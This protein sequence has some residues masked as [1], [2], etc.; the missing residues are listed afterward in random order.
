MGHQID[1]RLAR[2]KRLFMLRAFLVGAGRDVVVQVA[3]SQVPEH[4]HPDPRKLC[5]QFGIGL[6]NEVTN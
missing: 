4:H 1:F 5:C 3:V 2:E 6:F